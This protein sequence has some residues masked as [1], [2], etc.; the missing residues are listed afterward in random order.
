MHTKIDTLIQ[1]LDITP[2]M[3]AQAKRQYEEI[4]GFFLENGIHADFYPQDSF[5]LG[6]VVRPY[7]RGVKYTICSLFHNF[8]VSQRRAYF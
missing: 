2:Q 7:D 8:R 5:R 1:N 3:Y 4:A 6:T